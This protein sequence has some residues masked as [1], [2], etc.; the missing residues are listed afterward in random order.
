MNAFDT[1]AVL[2]AIAATCG[3]LNHRLLGLP[4]T[5]GTLAVA[6]IGSMAIV[7]V[8]AFAPAWSLRRHVAAFLEDIDFNRTLMRGLLSFLLFAGALHDDLEG[9]WQHRRSGRCRR[10][11]WSCPRQSWAY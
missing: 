8:E 7:V 9:L 1:A 11:A 5:G 3:Y 10:L 4:A 6:L 2:L